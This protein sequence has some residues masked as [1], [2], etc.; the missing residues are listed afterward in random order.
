MRPSSKHLNLIFLYRLPVLALCTFIAWQSSYPSLISEPLFAYDD[1][2]IHFGVYALLA[3]LCAR[4]LTAEKPF[5]SPV[6]I[7]IITIFFSCFFGIS[8]E[9]HQAF[10]PSRCASVPDIIADGAGSIAGCL[11]YLNFSSQKK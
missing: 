5:W 7:T 8:D 6:K 3:I 9:I 10:V 11:F 1:K 2:V 4:D